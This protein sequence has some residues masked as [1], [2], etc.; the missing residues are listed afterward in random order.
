MQKLKVSDKIYCF[1]GF[2]KGRVLRDQ[3]E[4]YDTHGIYE[5]LKSENGIQMENIVTKEVTQINTVAYPYFFGKYV[6]I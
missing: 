5:V 1:D 6:K 2:G 4:L 3:T